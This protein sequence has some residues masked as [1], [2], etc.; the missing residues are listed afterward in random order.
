VG[1]SDTALQEFLEQNAASWGEG[2]E[3][4]WAEYQAGKIDVCFS[5]S[6]I[7]T[8]NANAQTIGWP[9]GGW[10]IWIDTA[11]YGNEFMIMVLI[12]HEW[13]HIKL[14]TYTG[15]ETAE[16]I[17]CA[18]AEADCAAAEDITEFA[19]GAGP[20]YPPGF[21]EALHELREHYIKA[22]EVCNGNWFG[23]FP[24]DCPELGALVVE[25]C[26]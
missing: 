7:K 16:E 2:G 4:F 12:L 5:S 8:W 1:C 26:L 6:I 22:W 24:G 17:A 14:H 23:G 25:V 19:Q 13:A 21:C 11:F 20:P 3:E 9:D 10:Q 18:E 15:D